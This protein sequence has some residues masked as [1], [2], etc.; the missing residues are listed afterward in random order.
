[1]YYVYALYRS[2]P[3]ASWD[4]YGLDMPV[5]AIHPAAAFASTTSYK[6]RLVALFLLIVLIKHRI[7]DK[8]APVHQ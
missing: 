6:F 2:M 7:F 5:V 4:D 1:M 8:S 3:L